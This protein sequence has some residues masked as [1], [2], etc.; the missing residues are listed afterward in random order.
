MDASE[1]MILDG[2]LLRRVRKM[3]QILTIDNLRK[4][5][6]LVVDWCCMCKQSGESIDHLLLHCSGTIM[7]DFQHVW[8]SVG[9]ASWGQGV[10]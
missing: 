8:S 7:V 3:G 9:Y 4:Q 10:I 2:L 6:V 5:R 1:H